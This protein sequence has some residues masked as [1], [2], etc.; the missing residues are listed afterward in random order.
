MQAKS[1]TQTQLIDR[2]GSPKLRQ[3]LLAHKTPDAIKA[4]RAETSKGADQPIP[5]EKPA[6]PTSEQSNAS[7]NVRKKGTGRK[8]T[9]MFLTDEDDSLALGTNTSI[10]V[11][12]GEKEVPGRRIKC[13][14]DP[15]PYR[16][17]RVGANCRNKSR[18]TCVERDTSWDIKASKL[19]DKWQQ[20]HKKWVW[21]TRLPM[22]MAREASRV[23]F[24][25]RSHAQCW[26]VIE[27][28][29]AGFLPLD[30]A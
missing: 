19:F 6:K 25:Q 27:A 24:D 3:Q 4:T 10:G 22:Q 9:Q 28:T 17:D 11:S 21:L 30:D 18:H 14:G 26:T 5:L 29:K 15:A 16:L 20:T 7:S 23:P 2:I 1:P 13:I 8:L 12:N